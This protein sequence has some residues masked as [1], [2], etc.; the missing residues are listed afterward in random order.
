M[1]KHTQTI[2]WL[3]SVFGRFVGLALKGL[4]VKNFGGAYSEI[5]DKYNKMIRN[6][7]FSSKTF[8]RRDCSFCSS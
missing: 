5:N 4:R 2:R 7:Q 8:Q 3:L 6:Q 1:V